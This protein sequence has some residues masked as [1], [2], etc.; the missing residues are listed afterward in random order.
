M[1]ILT[2]TTMKKRINPLGLMMAAAAT[3]CLVGIC[4]GHTQHFFGFLTAG[5]LAYALLTE[6]HDEKKTI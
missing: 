4:L 1:T 5:G 3:L 6:N 2:P